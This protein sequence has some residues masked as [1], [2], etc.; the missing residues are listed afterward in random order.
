RAPGPVR[1]PPDRLEAEGRAALEREGAAAAALRA[2]RALEL[3]YVG[4]DT[5]LPV[6]TPADGDFGAA[7]T[8]A[9]RA[10]YGYVRPERAVE[11]VAARVRVRAAEA[12]PAAELAPSVGRG[13]RP[14]AAGGG[15]GVGRRARARA[16]GRG[17]SGR[18]ARAVDRQGCAAGAAARGAGLVPGLG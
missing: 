13:G 8:A 11:V 3:R 10:R 18:G 12:G 1:A 16:G 5:A 7:F 6:D 15:G 4:T 17:G 14:R 2:E 9:H